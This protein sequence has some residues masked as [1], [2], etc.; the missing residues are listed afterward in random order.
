M[1]EKTVLGL[2]LGL[3][4]YII[5]SITMVTIVFFAF[6]LIDF[7]TGVIGSKASGEKYDKKKAEQG[8]WK[9]LGYLIFWIMGVLVELVIHTQG[10]SI[11]IDVSVPIVSLAVT[12]WLLGTEGLSILYNL[13]RMGVKG[14]PKWF[15]NYFDKMKATKQ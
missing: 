10:A 8:V 14:I 1:K 11:G 9:K 12:F 5:G 15:V 2:I 4:S 7:L 3:G 13:D 6:M